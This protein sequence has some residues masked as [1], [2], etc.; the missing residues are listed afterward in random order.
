M[1]NFDIQP[2]ET[3]KCTSAQYDFLTCED[4]VPAAV[5]VTSTGVIERSTLVTDVKYETTDDK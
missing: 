5:A 3:L 1:T 4:E 2:V